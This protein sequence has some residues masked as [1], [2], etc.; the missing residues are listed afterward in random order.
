MLGGSGDFRQRQA[1]IAPGDDVSRGGDVEPGGKLAAL[2]GSRFMHLEQL[3]VQRAPE[4][5]KGELG[6]FRSYG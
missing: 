2:D 4:E 6:D 3:G 1:A 5:L